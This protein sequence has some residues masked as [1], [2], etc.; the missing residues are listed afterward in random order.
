MIVL[1]TLEQYLQHRI[2]PP[3]SRKEI[4]AAFVQK[5]EERRVAETKEK[6]AKIDRV[7]SMWNNRVAWWKQEFKYA[8]DFKY[9]ETAPA[10]VGGSNVPAAAPAALDPRPAPHPEPARPGDVAGQAIDAI[11]EEQTRRRSESLTPD[12]ASGNR[13]GARNGGGG[14]GGGGGLFGGGGAG[15]ER[16]YDWGVAADGAERAKK[17]GGVTAGMPAEATIAIKE[18]S[19]DAE[20][21]KALAAAKR[22]DAYAIYTDQSKALRSTPAFYLDAADFFAKRGDVALAVRILTNIPELGLDD[23][24]LLRIAAHRLGQMKQFDLAIDLFEKVSKLRPEE[25]QSFRDLALA[26]ADRGD[27]S[28][29]AAQRNLDYT[30]ALELLH[31]VVMGEWQRFEEIEVLALMEANRILA[32]AGDV[33]HSFD[34]RL[35]Q[36]LDLDLRVVMT[37]D[38]D[39]TDI[40][41]HVIEPSG[42]EA[43]YGHARTTI[44]GLVSRDFTQGYG[45]EEYAL[46]KLMPGKYVIKANFYG[47]RDQKLVGPTTVQATVITNFGRGNERRQSLTLRLKDAKD[48]VEVGKV[49]LK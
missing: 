34:K 26:H 14:G 9:V 36:L 3:K 49:T 12:R 6:A 10:K 41:L 23:G 45:P 47:N 38:T 28:A 18:W 11:R 7:L 17:G 32:K 1:E 29:D 48:M 8:G 4:Y 33:S 5:I 15:G 22:E 2:V 21:M 16:G 31:K 13:G 40:D 43:F 39:N 42:E 27:A 44:G 20:Y 46:R 24:R 25:P 30:R 35:I 19:P 37:W